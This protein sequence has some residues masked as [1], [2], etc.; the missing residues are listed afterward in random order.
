LQ[1][2]RRDVGALHR[3]LEPARHLHGPALVPEVALDF[4]NDRGRGE[5]GKLQAALRLEALDR[6]EQADVADLD[7]VL[8]RLA[9]VAE[10]LG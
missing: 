10:F 7:D 5:G 9:S 8:E 2:L 4:A 3:F 6:C 1:P